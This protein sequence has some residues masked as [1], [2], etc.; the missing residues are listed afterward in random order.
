MGV[1]KET[2]LDGIVIA[3]HNFKEADR[4]ITLFSLE[5]GKVSFVARGVRKLTSKNKNSVELLSFGEY[6]LVKGKAYQLLKQGMLKESFL[7]LRMDFNKMSVALTMSAFLKEV[8]PLN[9]PQKEVFDL[10]VWSLRRLEKS[11]DPMF[12]LRYFLVKS[13]LLLGYKPDLSSCNNCQKSGGDAFF[14]FSTGTFIC[15]DCSGQG[16]FLEE[17]I[18]KLYSFLEED[19]LKKIRGLEL[20]LAQLEKFDNFLEKLIEYILERKFNGFIFL[21]KIKI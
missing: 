7:Y 8:L 20:S 12:L 3:S 19:Q 13:I 16:F 15:S 10:F 17:K 11:Q 18:L 1:Q 5:Q 2:H 6:F 4:S 9:V 14:N 21:K